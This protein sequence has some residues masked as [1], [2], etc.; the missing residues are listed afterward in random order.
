MQRQLRALDRWYAAQATPSSADPAAPSRAEGWR[1]FL[2]TSAT[3]VTAVVAALVLLHSQGVVV[4]LDGIGRRVGRGPAVAAAGTGAHRFAMHQRNQPEVPVTYDPCRPIRVVV[5]D[6]QAPAGAEAILGSAL[7]EVGAATG[8][9]FVRAGSSDAVP[10]GDRASVQPGSGRK[11]PT[12]L[13]AWVSP[14]EVP[15]LHGKVAGL[16]GSGAVSDAVT[17]RL[18]YVR[19]EIS[20]DAP[21]MRRILSRPEGALAARAIVMHELG[22]VVGLAHVDD[23]TELMYERNEGRT[24]WGPGDLTGLEALGTGLCTG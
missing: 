20:L 18:T 16:G 12:V 13:V 4:S 1:R 3:T 15:R 10:E 14:A 8:L 23:P 22:H 17:G 24:D 9:T 19:G 7:E 5:N 2:V 6:D 21:T 11:R